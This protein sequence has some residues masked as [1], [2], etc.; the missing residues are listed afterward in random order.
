MRRIAAG[1]ALVLGAVLLLERSAPSSQRRTCP[2]VPDPARLGSW[3]GHQPVHR[4][5]RGMCVVPLCMAR[6]PCPTHD[7]QLTAE[8]STPESEPEPDEPLAPVIEL[9][10]TYPP[11]PR[12]RRPRDD[13]K[14]RAAA[15]LAARRLRHAELARDSPCVGCGRVTWAM[16]YCSRCDPTGALNRKWRKERDASHHEP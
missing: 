9:A 15:R 12:R 4:P 7:I 1:A 13:N 2:L 6:R 16:A 5:M 11:P 3:H 14:V 10:A 8:T